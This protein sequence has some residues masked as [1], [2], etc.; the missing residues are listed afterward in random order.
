MIVSAY[1]DGHGSYGLRVL[2]AD[3]SLN[4]R[5]EWEN[6]TVYLPDERDPISVP[7]SPS[8]WEGSP[9]IRSSHIKAFFSRNELAPW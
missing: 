1:H 6:V 5:P 4:F 3:V 9:E 8:F 7:L 2:E